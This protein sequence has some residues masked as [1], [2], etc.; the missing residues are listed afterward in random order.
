MTWQALWD[1]RPEMAEFGGQSLAGKVAYLATLRE[2]GSPRVH[3]VTPIVGEGHLFLFMEPSSP[4]S[5]DLQRDPRY[6]LHGSVADAHGDEGEFAVSGRARRVEGAE[7][8]ETAARLSSYKPADR[9]VLFELDVER[10]S[11]TVYL[12]GHASREEWVR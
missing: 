7:Q 12:C 6:S 4:K 3:P 10:A 2:D 8:R 9:A 11:S 1:A 5:L